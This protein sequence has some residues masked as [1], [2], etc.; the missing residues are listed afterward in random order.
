[1]SIPAGV[2]IFGPENGALWVLT[3][4]TGAAAAAGHNLLIHVSAWEATLHVGD[5]P[6]ETS[7]VFAADAT[8]LRV[9]EGTGGMQPLGDLDKESIQEAIDDEVLKR[10]VIE[11]R[12]T[13]V[14]IAD[15]GGQIGVQG[16]L[17]L[18]GQTRPISFE[19]EVGDD[20]RISGRTVITQ[21]K[22]EITPYSTL[23]GA[24][25]VGDEVEVVI[26]ASSHG[27]T[28][29]EPDLPDSLLAAPPGAPLVDPNISSSIWA[30]VFGV[31][32]WFAMA[33]VGVSIA[34]A[35]ALALAASF[36]IFVFVRTYG[37][38]RR[39]PKDAAQSL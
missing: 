30:G 31:Y 9:R 23:F 22:W 2:H 16:D 12:S 28:A 33:S 3:T 18:V 5:D 17:T 32:L 21:S 29:D 8:S 25:K 11:F 38:G 35:L 10:M 36:P 13:A 20:D 39:P 37:V 15:D 19:L 26:D 27:S 14:Q 1:V 24:L 34:A 6:A 4:R 7:V